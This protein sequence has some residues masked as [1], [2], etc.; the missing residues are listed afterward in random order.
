MD[1]RQPH[2]KRTLNPHQVVS[3]ELKQV[4]SAMV[5]LHA[6][7]IVHRDLK[8][9]NVLIASDGRLCISDFGVIAIAIDTVSH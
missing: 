4:A 9:S 2:L 1:R 6:K 7:D 8:S 5:H 3:A